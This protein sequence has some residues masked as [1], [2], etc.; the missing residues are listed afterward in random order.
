MKIY[1]NLDAHDAKLDQVDNNAQYTTS[2][3][4]EL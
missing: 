1:R 3:M 2:H 4:H